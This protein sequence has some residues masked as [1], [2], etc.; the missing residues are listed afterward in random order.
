MELRHLRYFV[1]VAEELHFR[2]AAERLH[3]AQPA[4]SEQVRKLEQELGVKLFDRSQRSVEL[5][6]AGAALLEEARHVLRHAEVAQQAARNSGD[7]ATTRLRIG[8]LLDSLPTSIPRALRRLAGSAPRVHLDL[9]TGPSLRL[10][11]E[12]RERLLDAVIASLPAPTTGLRVAPLGE[13]RA[14]AVLPATHPHAVASAI[15]LG[16]L[17]PDRLVVLP[18]EV[19]PPFNNAI[20]AMCH[21]A[22]LAPTFVEMPEPRV[23]HVLLAVAAGAGLALLPETV[24]ERFAAPGI[25]FVALEAGDAAFRGAVL[26][27][28]DADSLATHAFLRALART[29]GDGAAHSPRAAVE[30]AA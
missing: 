30:L 1:A 3:V 29:A 28:P 2:R 4:V 18:R 24:T 12:V 16:R 20:V 21:S 14:V 10:I 7:L 9:T 17:A 11:D 25:R 6:V 19:N 13:Q 5:T 23:E 27:H 15:A 26:T 22:G 8:Y